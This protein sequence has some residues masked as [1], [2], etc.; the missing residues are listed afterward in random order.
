MS[1]LLTL[2]MFVI[3]AYSL[4]VTIRV[5]LQFLRVNPRN[6]LADSVVRFTD[7]PTKPL[8][9]LLGQPY[10]IDLAAVVLCLALETVVRI[11]HPWYAAQIRGE[12]IT[13]SIPLLNLV[14]ASLVA[15]PFE[16]L[17]NVVSILIVLLIIRVILSFIPLQSS[18]MTNLISDASNAMLRPF[19][20]F[21]LQIGMFDLTPAILLILLWFANSFLQDMNLAIWTSFLSN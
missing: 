6:P 19:R 2:V 9:K 15:S 8:R 21:N 3:G 13:E 12:E 1:V 10:R 18:P 11:L 17:S 5:L 4:L 7:P 16:L 14:L 20:N